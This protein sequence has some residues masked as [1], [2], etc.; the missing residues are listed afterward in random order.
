MNLDDRLRAASEAL[1]DG[2]VT[3][4]DAAS[5]LREIVHVGRSLPAD[6]TAAAPAQPAPAPPASPRLRRT[7]RLALAV[8]LA[9]VL[10]LGVVLVV[11]AAGRDRDADTSVL[12]PPATNPPT[13][14][15]VPRPLVQVPQACLDSNELADEII[16]KLNRNDRDNRLALALRDW[17]VATQRCRREAAKAGG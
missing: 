7:Q 12:T 8:N 15:V 1:K 13:N 5:G 2:S 9:L 3:Q 11:V 16:S 4:V 14:T 10:V 17:S 6:P